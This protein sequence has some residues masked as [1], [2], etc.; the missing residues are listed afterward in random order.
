MV[1]NHQID[2]ELG[3]LIAS[4]L[5]EILHPLEARHSDESGPYSFMVLWEE[6]G[7]CHRGMHSSS[8]HINTDYD[9]NQM[10]VDYYDNKFPESCAD[11][12]SEMSQE[13]LRF[14]SNHVQS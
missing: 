10:V 4:N 7:R 13:E 11:E 1:C 12:K 3:L 9:L 14:V 5:P 8:F 6:D 2:A